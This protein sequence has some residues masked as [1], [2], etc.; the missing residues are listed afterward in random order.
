VDDIAEYLVG[1]DN[2]AELS[3]YVAA[4][5]AEDNAEN[6]ASMLLEMKR[7]V[8]AS[9][10]GKASKRGECAVSRANTAKGGKTKGAN[11]KERLMQKRLDAGVESGNSWEHWEG[12]ED[13][14]AATKLGGYKKKDE[15]DYF[16]GKK[17]KTLKLRKS[18]PMRSVGGVDA[19]TSSPEAGKKSSTIQRTETVD[20]A[21]IKRQIKAGCYINCTN[22]GLIIYQHVASC[23]FCRQTLQWDK[24]AKA[25]EGTLKEEPV[26]EREQAAI[27]HKQRLLEYDRSSAQRTYV[28]DDQADYFE[29]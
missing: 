18:A 29:R 16:Q 17:K 25:P 13:E 7:D 12:Q 9:A 23:S 1:I 4:L 14:A 27:A 10:G 5:G 24:A 8:V 11:Q 26:S 15:D 21:F 22:C 20:A 2:L 28:F 6:F 19:S 3:E